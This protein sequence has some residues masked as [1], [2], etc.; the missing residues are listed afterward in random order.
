MDQECLV[1]RAALL[2]VARDQGL[3]DAH[4]RAAVAVPLIHGVHRLRRRAPQARRLALARRQSGHHHPRDDAAVHRRQPRIL[5][6]PRVAGAARRRGRSPAAGNSCPPPISV[7]RRSGL[8]QP[9]PP[10]AHAVRR[11]GAADQS[12]HRARH[13]PG[14]HPVRAG[15]A[16]HRTASAGCGTHRRRDAAPAGCR[17]HAGGGRARPQDHAGRRPR[18]RHRAGSRRARRRNRILRTC[19]GIGG[20]Q[21][22]AH[23]RLSVAPKAR[24]HTCPPSGADRQG[25]QDGHGSNHR[26]R[27]RRDAGARRRPAAHGSRR[28]QSERHRRRHSIAAP[29]VRHR[30]Q[31]FGKIHAGA[32]RSVPR[33]AAGQG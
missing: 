6:Q 1:R 15:R 23:R 11:R 27:R 33:P 24:R 20:G 12:H 26:D 4:P 25:G 30:R 13:I 14:Q 8:S 16:L 29:G 10:V 3:Q 9:R 28:A 32:R 5:R 22:L 19:P 7:R 31:R 17:Q 18:T 2:C 21:G